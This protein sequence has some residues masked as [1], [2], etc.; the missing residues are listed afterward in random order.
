MQ[1]QDALFRRGR[2]GEEIIAER[3]KAEA[4]ARSSSALIINSVYLAGEQ[5]P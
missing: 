3:Y 2:S 1:R 5:I 4:L